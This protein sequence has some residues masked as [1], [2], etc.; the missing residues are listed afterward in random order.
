[1]RTARQL[2]DRVD[3]NGHQPEVREA[4]TKRGVVGYEEVRL[5]SVKR[6]S[7]EKWINTDPFKV[8]VCETGVME[9]PETLG[10]TVQLS[11][12]FSED[13]AGKVKPRTSSGLLT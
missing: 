10:C 7:I 12:H 1:M 8:P 6:G 2:L 11:P 5:G 4:G 3:G 13:V 9:V